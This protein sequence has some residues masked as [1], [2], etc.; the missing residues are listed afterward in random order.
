MKPKTDITP[1]VRK[2]IDDILAGIEHEHGVRI[3][4]AIESGSRAW[5]FAS[6]DSDFDVRFVYVHRSQWYLTVEKR[7]D[8]IERPIEG[9]FDVGGWDIRKAL[10]L[11]VGGNA[12]LVEW[13]NSPVTYWEN[14]EVRQRL[15]EVAL[16][17]AWRHYLGAHY[18]GYLHG[19]TARYVV[20]KDVVSLKKYFYVLRPAVA[21]AWLR[22][23]AGDGSARRLIPT[24]FLTLLEE[25]DL[26]PPVRA[27]IDA[28]L[29]HK[30]GV[31]ESYVEPVDP[32]LDAY[33]HR[34]FEAARDLYR[35]PRPE[36][37]RIE[38]ADRLLFD[39][40]FGDTDTD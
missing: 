29:E 7:R 22:Q 40:V 1:D 4:F 28:C 37:E 13:I 16:T 33:A 23:S 32:I 17:G 12:V 27:A 38:A 11:L 19:K 2:R 30:A 21:L 34:E 26:D 31:S 39:I 20:G 14:H 6:P 8:V 10:G 5:G 9:L 35:K 3:L 15:G 18:S 25:T 24:S 36:Q